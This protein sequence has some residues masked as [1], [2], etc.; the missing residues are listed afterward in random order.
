MLRAQRDEL[1]T[2][3]GTEQRVDVRKPFPAEV[4]ADFQLYSVLGS[5]VTS[6]VIGVAFA[7][8]VP[9]VT[10]SRSRPV[11]SGTGN[12]ASRPAVRSVPVR[13]PNNG[14]VCQFRGGF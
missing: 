11:S 3:H 7:C 2:D 5:A 6:T 4:L 14:M 13:A 1:S 8:V 12:A 10:T 9:H